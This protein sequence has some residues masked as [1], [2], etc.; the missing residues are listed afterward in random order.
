MGPN[1]LLAAYLVGRAAGPTPLPEVGLAA[2]MSARATVTVYQDGA[3]R[4][5]Q[6][7]HATA[8]GPDVDAGPSDHADGYVISFDLDPALFA[9]DACISPGCS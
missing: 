9:D 4:T 1:A 2:A 6:F 7:A 5:Q 3:P 8:L